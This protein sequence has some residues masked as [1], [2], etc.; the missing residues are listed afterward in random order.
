MENTFKAYN[1]YSLNYRTKNLITN[2]FNKITSYTLISIRLT[3]VKMKMHCKAYC[4]VGTDDSFLLQ[5]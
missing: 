5:I 2:G 4:T 3:T 1:M